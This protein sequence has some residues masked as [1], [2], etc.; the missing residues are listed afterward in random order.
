MCPGRVLSR[1]GTGAYPCFIARN[2]LACNMKANKTESYIQNLSKTLST[3]RFERYLAM[4]NN[5]AHSAIDL[6]SI[7]VLLSERLYCG[8]HMLEVT[9]RNVI[10]NAL[11]SAYHSE[12]YNDDT[13]VTL[14][15]QKKLIAEAKKKLGR[16]KHNYS[17]GH[18]IAE[19][20]LG[21]WTSFF[22]SEYET[23]WQQTLYKIARTA[24]GKHYKRKYFSKRLS[25]IRNLRNRV[26]HHE[27]ITHL[28][29]KLLYQDIVDV[30]SA[31]SPEAYEWVSY[32][33]SFPELL[34][35][36]YNMRV[37]RKP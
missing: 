9:L 6:Y 7:N 17:R 32:H 35:K 4:C 19:L 36:Y 34:E 15:L 3:E 16:F 12:W 1:N 18:V 37:D 10:D 33:S 30:I 13:I 21:F 31:L 22:H 14:P 2:H 20:N 29:L 11:S 26:A 24:E 23:L 5:N 27:P 8:L 25:D 28:N